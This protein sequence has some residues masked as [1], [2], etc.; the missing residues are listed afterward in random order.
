MSFVSNTWPGHHDVRGRSKSVPPIF[1]LGKLNDR[2]RCGYVAITKYDLPPDLDDPTGGKG[3]KPKL[4][5][6]EEK[7][8]KN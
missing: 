7:K 1:Y 5:T 3:E 4:E 2:Q 8:A 6:V